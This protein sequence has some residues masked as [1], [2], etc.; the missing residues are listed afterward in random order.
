METHAHMDLKENELED[1]HCGI[2][3]PRE[4]VALVSSKGTRPTVI[5][6]ETLSAE[7][8]E[9]M[10]RQIRGCGITED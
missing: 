5:L 4:I 2:L 7:E 6:K 1:L 8:I 10:E 3:L 9:S